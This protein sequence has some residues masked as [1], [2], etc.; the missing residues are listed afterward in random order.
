MTGELLTSYSRTPVWTGDAA[1]T[2]LFDKQD[3]GFI[4]YDDRGERPDF[5]SSEDQKWAVDN[6]INL[7]WA[8]EYKI[9]QT[10]AGMVCDLRYGQF[11]FMHDDDDLFTGYILSFGATLDISALMPGG[12]DDDSLPAPPKARGTS[13]AANDA[14]MSVAEWKPKNPERDADDEKEKDKD[15]ASRQGQHQRTY[16]TALTR[17]TSASMPRPRSCCP[18]TPM[19]SRT[20]W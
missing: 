20:G 4:A 19:L 17:A 18:S 8:S 12:K 7:M 6:K 3:Y 16:S 5:E 14:G 15:K 10:I 2:P 1:I 13:S 11:G 9:L